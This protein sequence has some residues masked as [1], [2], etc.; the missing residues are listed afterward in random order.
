LRYGGTTKP[1]PGEKAT[2]WVTAVDADTGAVKWKY[3]TEAPV[4]AAITP[5]AGGVTF[6]GDS[7]GNFHVFDSRSGQVLMSKKL[8]GAFG[9]GIITYAHR[10]KQFVAATTGN[11]SRLTFGGT[12]NPSLVVF[13]L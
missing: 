6:A 1:V 3:R 5:T 8:D 12:G 7:G 11:I 10:G 13:G 2:G 9:G 4:V